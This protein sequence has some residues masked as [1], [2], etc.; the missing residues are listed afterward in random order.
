[1][2]ESDFASANLITR[3]QAP[4]TSSEN[5]SDRQT[6]GAIFAIGRFIGDKAQK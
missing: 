1:V 2:A 4:P 5:Q 3:W 6:V